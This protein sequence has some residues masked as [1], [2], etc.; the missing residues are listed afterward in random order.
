MPPRP[1]H[2]HSYRFR[3][4]RLES[5]EDRSLFSAGAPA[6]AVRFNVDPNSYD[7]SSILVR[8]TSP[9]RP[10][11]PSGPVG[12][13]P[14]RPIALVP[15][16]YEVHLT[17]GAQPAA[18]LDMYRGLAG[19]KYAE[20]NYLIHV[21]NTPNDTK[22]ADGT[23]WA[24]NNTGQSGGTADADI[25]A[26]EAWD[27]ATGGST[28]V[29][30]IDTGVD[31]NHPD[32]AAN[33]WTNAAEATGIAGVD[34]DGNGFV[35]DIH[36]WDFVNNDNNPMDDHSH[37]THVSGTIGAIGNNGVGVVG[38]NWNVKIMPL[39]FLNAQGSGTTANAIL[40]LQYAVAN[41][42]KISN[43]SYGDNTFSQANL[44]AIQAAGAAGHLVV[45]AAGNGNFFGFPIN[46]DTTPFYPASY[47]PS[48]DNLIA[49]AATDRTDHFAS[50]SNY[51]A[52]SVDLAAPGVSIYST[53]PNNS[54]GFKDGTSMAAPHV[55]GAAALVWSAFPNL[56]VQQVKQRLLDNTDPIGNLNPSRPTVTNGRLNVFKALS[57][58]Q[59]GP[60][61]SVTD[62]TVTEGDSGTV[63]VDFT[64]SLPA[65]A[66]Q[67]MSVKF[68]TANGTAGA[69]DYVSNSGTLTFAI[70][71]VSK[72][73]TVP[74]NGD[75]LDEANETFLVNLT[76]PVNASIAD[77][78][79]VG[80]IVDDDPAPTLAIGDVS[81]AE[82][83]RGTTAFTFTVTLSA[84]S[85]QSVTVS[86][87][88]ANGTAT[89]GNND[90][91][92]KSGTLTFA[93]GETSKTIVVSVKGDRRGEANETFFVNLTGPTNATLADG[94]GVGTILNDD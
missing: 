53:M 90:Y 84:V 51:G 10:V 25:D 24:M 62:A 79:G 16:L 17:E 68:A 72:T 20:P 74:G 58:G 13:L 18:I 57:A 37:G 29:A 5:L 44:D 92:A 94:Q 81:L 78:Q 61:L 33:I 27:I 30:V 34:D 93:P 19:I 75:T 66:E 85:G 36:G 40:A 6:A 65:P 77:G 50:F 43:H 48:A 45:A 69:S 38:V 63:N 49:V 86:Y 80:T 89:T 46:N 91:S 83:N 59:T 52:T 82:G 21:E 87:A 67:E 26:P 73:V 88:T 42:A 76:S 4:P 14:G 12:V 22:Y 2:R 55:T 71:D 54:Y 41:G 15:G 11:V 35:D 31:Y 39:K 64:V 60:G 32:L 1:R 23:L 7:P 8:F 56:T 70:G 47:Q 9:D 3:A 28:V